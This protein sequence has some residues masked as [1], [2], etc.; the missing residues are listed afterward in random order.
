MNAWDWFVRYVGVFIRLETILL[1]VLLSCLFLSCA[2][3]QVVE[4]P[5]PVVQVAAPA[6]IGE[7][8]AALARF[9]T[10]IVSEVNTHTETVQDQATGMVKSRIDA[11]AEQIKNQNIGVGS[12]G[13]GVIMLY[14]L[15][16]TTIGAVFLYLI[17][18]RVAQ[19]VKAVPETAIKDAVTDEIGKAIGGGALRKLLDVLLALW[20]LKA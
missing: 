11:T 16:V 8:K 14:G 10:E 13:G 4:N 18:H 2:G 19:G 1:G 3:P 7:V 9:K 17:L 12:G 6:T 15:G 5:D 20:G